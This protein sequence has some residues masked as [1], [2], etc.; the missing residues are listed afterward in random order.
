MSNTGKED[1]MQG[2]KN[3]TNGASAVEKITAHVRKVCRPEGLADMVRTIGGGHVD[4]STRVLRAALIEVYFE[5]F[6]LE[7]GENLC[8]EIG[9]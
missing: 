4:E 9:F 7:A 6:G 1:T 5:N 3:N 2:T 8:A